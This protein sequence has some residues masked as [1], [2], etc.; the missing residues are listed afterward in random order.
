VHRFQAM[1]KVNSRPELSLKV[2]TLRDNQVLNHK[3]Y[4]L[5]KTLNTYTATII[6]VSF[7]SRLVELLVLHST[8]NFFAKLLFLIKK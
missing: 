2:V 5:N 8:I 6:L 1:K 7:Y 4:Y 3:K